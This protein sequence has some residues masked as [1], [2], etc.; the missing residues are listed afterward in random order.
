MV[1]VSSCVNSLLTTHTACFSALNHAKA[2]TGA[3]TQ[4]FNHNYATNSSGQ[5]PE[6]STL[7]KWE[8]FTLLEMNHNQL[9]TLINGFTHAKLFTQDLVR[10]E[11]TWS[12]GGSLFPLPFLWH[13]PPS[14]YHPDKAQFLHHVRTG[15]PVTEATI[16]LSL[17]APP[18]IQ[19]LHPPK[20][21]CLSV[22]MAL[23]FGLSSLLSILMYFPANSN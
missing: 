18:F 3:Q 4:S 12:Q 10:A 9:S 15:S 1:C 6:F 22:L 19:L 8:I 14:P 5:N 20:Y 7:G 11:L 2:G 16:S 23:C 17:N 13:S 21:L